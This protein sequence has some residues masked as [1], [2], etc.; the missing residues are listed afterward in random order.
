M[1]HP[2]LAGLQ[3]AAGPLLSVFQ[4]KDFAAGENGGPRVEF[5]VNPERVGWLMK[6]GEHIKTWRAPAPAPLKRTALETV[7]PLSASLKR[8]PGPPPCRTRR[9]LAAAA[10]PGAADG[11]ATCVHSADRML[12]QA[13]PGPPAALAAPPLVLTAL[14]CSFTSNYA[15]SGGGVLFVRQQS[16]V[17]QCFQPGAAGAQRSERARALPACC[18][19]RCPSR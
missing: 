11:A 3:T 13:Q 14:K 10:A 5:W 9:H 16:L 12:L 17:P 4:K 2:L 7:L 8:L 6:Q 1:A 19:H 18:P 15:G